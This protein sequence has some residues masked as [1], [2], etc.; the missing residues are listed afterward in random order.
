VRLR[1]ENSQSKIDWRY[2]SGDGEVGLHQNHKTIKLILQ[3]AFSPI[4]LWHSSIFE[5]FHSFLIFLVF[6]L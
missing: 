2:G 6:Y 3:K 1:L 5:A 4:I